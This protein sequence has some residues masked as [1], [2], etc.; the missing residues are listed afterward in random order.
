LH[1]EKV[2]YS[3]KDCDLYSEGVWFE[4]RSGQ[5]LSF[6]RFLV[7]FLSPTRKFQDS[8][9]NWV[10]TPP[11]PVPSN[12]L[13]TIIIVSA[14]LTLELLTA[15]LNKVTNSMESSSSREAASCS[16]TQELPYILWKPKLITVFTRAR[17]W[18][19]S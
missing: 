18:S 10:T 12:S 2:C 11:F 19:L 13:Y 4:S 7:Y 14:A 9:L 5:L 6:L 8:I 1:N 3:C 15:S 17:H 16:A